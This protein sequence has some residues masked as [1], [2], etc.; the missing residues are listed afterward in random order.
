MLV[1]LSLPS[2][3][4]K[5]PGE[6]G[7][8]DWNGEDNHRGIGNGQIVKGMEAQ[9]QRTG[10]R[11][12]T[13]HQ[14][15]TQLARPKRVEVVVDEHWDGQ[16]EDA[17][18]AGHRQFARMNVLGKHNTTRK[19]KKERKEKKKLVQANTVRGRNIPKAFHSSG[20]LQFG[21]TKAET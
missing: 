5:E 9:I 14:Q 6:D 18:E 12:A 8:E 3:L 21:G 15:V 10:A 11:Q 17:K 1:I 13:Q 4:E 20:A 7:H 19:R 16:Q 2:H